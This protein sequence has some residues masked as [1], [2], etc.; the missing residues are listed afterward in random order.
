MTKKAFRKQLHGLC[1]L[2]RETA[3]ALVT[4]WMYRCMLILPGGICLDRV[5][6]GNR[7]E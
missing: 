4:V 5:P 6:E 3:A 1:S 7:T 2:L